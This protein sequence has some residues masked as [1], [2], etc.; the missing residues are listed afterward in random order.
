M[1]ETLPRLRVNANSSIID[2]RKKANEFIILMENARQ[3]TKKFLMTLTDKVDLTLREEAEIKLL[4]R[5]LILNDSF[6]ALILISLYAINDY[7]TY[8]DA[9]EKYASKN[10]KN[11]I[12]LLEKAKEIAKRDREEPSTNSMI[13]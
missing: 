11:F 4:K 3:E 8:L 12:L 10:D 2:Y 6:N 13:S 5:T 1:S 7:K 9:L